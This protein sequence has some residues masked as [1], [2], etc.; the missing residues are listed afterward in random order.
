MSPPVEAGN[1]L[2]IPLYEPGPDNKPVT[3][4]WQQNLTQRKADY[5]AL[6]ADNITTGKLLTP[7]Q[8]SLHNEKSVTDHLGTLQVRPLRYSLLL[9]S[10]RAAQSRTQ[11]ISPK[12]VSSLKAVCIYLNTLSENS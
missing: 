4:N 6:T 3:V 5:F 11:I 8:S 1:E 2:L 9:S 10:T 12:L 7:K